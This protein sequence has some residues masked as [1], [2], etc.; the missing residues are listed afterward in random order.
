MTAGALTRALA[1]RAVAGVL[2]RGQTLDASLDALLTGSDPGVRALPDRD[3]AQVRALAF[4][5][6]RGHHR[7]QALLRLLLNK[8]LQGEDRLL[9]ALLSVGL[10]QLADPDQPD[11][12][13]VSA[14][15]AASRLLG[16]E[17]ASGLVNAS[18]RRYQRE[19]STLL[20]QLGRD[21]AAWHSHPAWLL[22]GLRAD[23]PDR[24]RKVATANQQ[25]P[26][27]WLRVNRLR[28]SA[29]DYA[30]RLGVEV[31]VEASPLPGFPDAL[32]LPS[33][34]PVHQLPGFADGLVSVQDAASQLAAPL[35]APEPGMRVLDACAAPGGKTTHLL[36]V[37]GGRLDLTAVDVAGGRLALVES[38]LKRLGLAATLLVGDATTPDAW[39]DGRPFDRILLDAPCTATGVIRRHPDIKL[40]RRAADVPEFARRQR[41]MLERLWPLLAPGG[42][43]L[44]STCS[45]LKAEN[46]GLVAE[47]LAAGTARLEP[48]TPAP[49]LQLLPGER[50]TD[51]FYYALMGPVAAATAAG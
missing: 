44:Y 15:V 23:W 49:G 43:F 39:W 27:F 5:A 16:Q 14:T 40:L 11:H 36:E 8:P 12:A 33:A 24:W 47:F 46:E 48:E 51:G 38:N 10:F 42:R 18:L 28:T 21:S 7:H 20:A 35:L 9:E 6:V 19:S 50:D 30:T 13:A 41:L 4:G 32:R 34:V 17:R 45:L 2:A 37:A 25:H 29:S 3:R 22:S 1:A 31:D 26:P